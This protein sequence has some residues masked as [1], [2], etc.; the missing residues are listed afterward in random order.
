MFQKFEIFMFQKFQSKMAQ[1]QAV[2]NGTMVMGPAE[3]QAQVRIFDEY[4]CY[5]CGYR[6]EIYCNVK[7]PYYERFLISG[8]S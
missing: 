7:A 1:Q 8:G 3:V 6:F 5:R 2:V 4:N